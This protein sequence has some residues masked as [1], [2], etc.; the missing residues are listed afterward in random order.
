MKFLNCLDTH[1]AYVYSTA[2]EYVDEDDIPDWEGVFT[3]LFVNEGM[4]QDSADRY[5]QL[6]SKK[7]ILM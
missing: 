5:N 2:G 3:H 7:Q 4:L 6:K 1:L